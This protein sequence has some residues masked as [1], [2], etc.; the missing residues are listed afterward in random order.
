MIHNKFIQL[1]ERRAY[2][3]LPVTKASIS[4]KNIIQGDFAFAKA[5]KS[6]TAFSDSPT[7]LL[8]KSAA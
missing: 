3:S 1:K 8:Y 7:Y 6:L 2:L 5:N 4:S